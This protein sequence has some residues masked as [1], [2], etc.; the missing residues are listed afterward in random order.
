MLKSYLKI[1]LRNIKRHKGYS[2]INIT[3]LALGMACCLLITIWVLD[4]L[5]YDKFHEN[6]ASL[7]RVEE[8]QDYSGRQLHVNLTPHPLAPPLKDEIPE[9]IDA[10]RYVWAGGLL[11]HYGDKVFFEDNIRAV[12]PS[13]FQMFTFPLLKGDENMALH[14]PYSLV[15]SE[16]I[17]E[18]YFGEEDPLGQIIS[19]NNQYD[20][21][22]TGIMKNVPHNS[23]LR[24]DIII[25]Y[26]FLRKTGKTDEEF[27]SNS[28][29]TF[30]KL[31]ENISLEQVNE[32]IFGFIRT[33]LPE[34]RTDL[35]LMPYTRIH[36]HSYFGWE[37]DSGAIQYIYIFSLIALFIILIACINFMN[38][39]TARSANR[40]KE[41]GL[42]K[43]VGAL[44]RHIIQQ[45]YGE[46]VIFAFIALIF[47]VVIVSLLLP[48]FSSLASKELSWSVTGIESILIGLLAIT[49]FTGLVAGS[50]PALFLSAFQ[51]VKVLRGSLKSGA[52]SSRFRK[53]LVVVQFSISILLI[54]G[55]TVVY[56]QLNFMKNRRL[57]WDKEHL[58]YIYLRADIKKSYEALKTELVK[59][60][61]ILGVTGVFQLPSY[62][63]GNSGGADWDGKDPEQQV[64]IGINVVDF[65]F[66]ETLK[67][68]MAEGRSFSREFSSDLSTSFIVNEEV[69]KIME[70][71]SVVG[72]RFSFVGVEGSIIGVMKN[73]HY[74]PIRN[75]IEPLAIHVFPDYINYMLIRIPPGSISESLQF[76]ENTWNRVIPDYPLEYRFLDEAFDRMYRTED[77]MG[78]L[79]KYFA[80]LAV[81]IACLGLFGLASFT[82]EQRTKEIGVRKV[83]G[84]SVSQVTLLLCKQFLLLVMLANVIACPVAYLVM[85]NWLQNYAYQTGLELFIFVAAMAAALVV[86]VIS[87]SFQAIRAAI[88]NPVDSLRYE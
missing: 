29:Q 32:K 27:G 79:L 17:A 59:D 77:R 82:A 10:T 5:S 41:V 54:I 18:K 61:R 52:G 39:S 21:T 80:V 67:I 35:V 28:I 73:F 43:V 8:N 70:K 11:F 88:S 58:V 49:L 37:K 46:S 33:R 51:P 47:A 71:E 83:L 4:E 60:S 62:N 3:G 74:Q 55:T 72:E 44:K 24:F 31:Q 30:V 38:L 56:K 68:E 12:D 78:T 48:A 26:E 23:Y 40:A 6:A 15:L 75:K 1:V 7:Y 2:F 34:S 65:D 69:A 81:F 57:G 84:A 13:F 36:L 25:P 19:I 50:Y 86:A 20:F 53:V 16:D 45:F 63:S 42:R 14:S 9:I 64:L 85:K 66:I 22:V 87:V 76:V